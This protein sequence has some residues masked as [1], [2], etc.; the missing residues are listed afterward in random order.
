M[1]ADEALQ[2]GGAARRKLDADPAPVH[3]V[4]QAAHESEAG[5]AIDEAH[6]ALVGDLESFGE[7]R[8]RR[9]RSWKASHEEEQL[10]LSRRDSGPSGLFFG[11]AQNR[12]SARRKRARRPYSASEIRRGVCLAMLKIYRATI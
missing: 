6:G 3:G 12:L 11:E 2:E 7:D 10:V 4:F 9:R 5:A 1:D 8:D